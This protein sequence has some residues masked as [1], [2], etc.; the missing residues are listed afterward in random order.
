MAITRLPR[1]TIEQMPQTSR[2]WMRFFLALSLGVCL[3]CAILQLRQAFAGA[4]VVQDDARQHVFWMRRFVDPELFPG[5]LIADYYQSAAPPAYAAVYRGVAALGIDPIV[6][7]KILPP[8]L[9]IISTLYC[10]AVTLELF[11]VPMAGFFA[12]LFLNQ[13]FW[14]TDDLASGTARAFFYPLVLAFFYY[15]VRGKMLPTLGAIA[16]QG[17][18]YPPAIF[19]AAG[20]LVLRLFRWQPG[21]LGLSS[22]R[23][24]YWISGLGLLVAGV[25]LLP[26]VL[27]NSSFGPT[28][29]LSQALTMP[30]FGDAGRTRFF[31]TNWR[32]FWFSAPRS[33]LL[34]SDWMYLP[35]WFMP[36]QFWL[37]LLLP[38][39]LLLPRQVPLARQLRSQSWLLV[40]VLLGSLGMFFLAHGVLFRLYLP[41]RYSQHNFRILAA[42]SGG[43]ALVMLVNGLVSGSQRFVSQPLKRILGLGVAAL[44]IGGTM[45][46]PALRP[47]VGFTFPDLNYYRGEYPGLYQFLANQPRDSVIASLAEEADF[48]PTFAQRS[49]LVA[50]EYALP[51]EKGYY[52]QIRQR[53]NDL[54]TAQYSPDPAVLERIIRQYGIDFWLI[55]RDAFIAES[56]QGNEWLMQ[57]QPAIENAIQTLKSENRPALV[58]KANQCI[59]WQEKDLQLLQASCLIHPTIP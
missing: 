17:L 8:I 34:P 32:E 54:I 20:V 3:V 42:I 51:Y 55:E 29:S 35:D 50:E 44:L 23:R 49:V 28:V 33:G 7:S 1:S 11:P 57:Y 15:L 46:Y 2:G 13:N 41:S 18:F 22:Q 26:V 4:Y 12:A 16:L 5:D 36:P 10:F 48:V 31:L 53:V 19:T 56:L 9:G 14:S 38:G 45:V 47:L 24:D 6:F 59:A 58:E 52:R 27:D 37:S 40:Q 21:R 25:S 30:E 39:L 43:I